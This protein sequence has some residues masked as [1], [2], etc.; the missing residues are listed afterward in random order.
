MRNAA[1]IVAVMLVVVSLGCS[2]VKPGP[3]QEA[4]LIRKP[5]IFGAGGVDPAP[6][7]TGRRYV[8]WSTDYV[9]VPVV[10]QA[11]QQQFDDMNSRD[12]VPLDFNAQM[13]LRVTDSARMIR[14][15]GTDLGV[16]YRNNVA[17]E[18]ESLTR[19]AVRNHVESQI[20]TIALDAIDTEVEQ[21]IRAHLKAIDIPFELRE[22]TVGKSNPPD[23][24]EQQRIAT[25]AQR[26]AKITEDER[27]QREIAR[28]AAEESRA[29]ADQAYNQKMGLNTEQ[30][31]AL[32]QIAMLRDTCR[33][34]TEQSGGCTFILGTSASP[35][36][37]IR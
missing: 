19:K 7:Q 6:V 13:T 27:N 34:G 17:K 35:L 8:A 22:I 1:A 12:G 32:Q 3:G 37:Q 23:Q 29:A 26:Q 33:R 16:I 5:W 11:F 4:V 28:R 15:F 9:T 18:F 25:A 14:E 2:S 24:I 30:Y 31:V 21:G 10:P 36:L 20:A